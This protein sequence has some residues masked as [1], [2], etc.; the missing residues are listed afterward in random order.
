MVAMEMIDP[1]QTSIGQRRVEVHRLGVAVIHAGDG[2]VDE[3]RG[4]AGQEHDQAHGED[5]DEKL[6][7][8]WPAGAAE[9]D[10]GDEGDAGDAVGLEAVGGGSDRVAGIVAGAVGDDAGVAGVVFLDVEDDLHQ[11]GADVGD[12]GEDSTGDAEGGGAERFTDGEAEEAGSGQIAG[13]NRRM[14]SIISNSTLISTMPT[15]MPA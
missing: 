2:F 6:G 13:T 15:L 5:P 14:T 11:V 10:E 4:H 8:E 1:S 9:E 7:L 12:L 3:V